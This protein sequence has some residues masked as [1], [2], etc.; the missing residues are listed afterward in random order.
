LPESADENKI[1]ASLK[2]GVLSIKV[3]KKEGYKSK[4]KTIEVN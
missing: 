1:N 2:N 4:L 3:A